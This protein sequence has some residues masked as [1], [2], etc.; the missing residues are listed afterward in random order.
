MN[1]VIIED[2][3]QKRENHKKA[4]STHYHNYVSVI[5]GTQIEF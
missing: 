5:M 3:Q 1:K 2:R 4:M